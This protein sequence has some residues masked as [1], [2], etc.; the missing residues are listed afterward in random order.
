MIGN[1]KCS[2]CGKRI[3]FGEVRFPDVH[4]S[5]TS[6]DLDYHFDAVVL[7]WN[8]FMNLNNRIGRMIQEVQE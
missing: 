7:C 2:H 6:Q 1:D 3:G 4:I 8:C 5:V